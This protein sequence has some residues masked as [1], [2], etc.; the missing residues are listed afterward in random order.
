MA[1]MCM[2]QIG[3]PCPQALSAPA[4]QHANV[5]KLGMGLGDRRQFLS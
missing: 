3:L 5:E 1:S 2:G 4:L